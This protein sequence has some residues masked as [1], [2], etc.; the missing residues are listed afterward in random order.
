[1]FLA[2]AKNGRFRGNLMSASPFSV[3]W[4]WFFCLSGFSPMLP[5]NLTAQQSSKMMCRNGPYAISV[6]TGIAPFLPHE[7]Y[8]KLHRL[9][10]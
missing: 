6:G 2:W 4:V 5:A 7:I 3:G 10:N 9:L 8:A 1:M